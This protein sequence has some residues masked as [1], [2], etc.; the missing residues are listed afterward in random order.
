M[1]TLLAKTCPILR[2]TGGRWP[3]FPVFRIR[4]PRILSI[5]GAIIPAQQPARARDPAR[6]GRQ[7]P[8]IPAF[9]A[10]VFATEAPAL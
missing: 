8:P 7:L 4:L 9:T 1:S 3:T 6:P 2:Q 5:K 10:S